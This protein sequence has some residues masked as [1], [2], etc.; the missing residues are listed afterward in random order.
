MKRQMAKET[1][2]LACRGSRSDSFNALL[3]SHRDFPKILGTV[4]RR[5]SPSHRGVR[6]RSRFREKD[7]EAH[8]HHGTSLGRPVASLNKEARALAPRP[9]ETVSTTPLPGGEAVGSAVEQTAWI[10]ESRDPE[11]RRR[12]RC[13][14]TARLLFQPKSIKGESCYEEK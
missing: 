3:L 8:R 11:N 2:A 7:F 10:S 5:S 12:M 1:S 6:Q 14:R 4:P 9:T 13:A